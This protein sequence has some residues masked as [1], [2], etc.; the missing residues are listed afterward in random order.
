M[1]A[2]PQ[3]SVMANT[4]ITAA[5]DSLL[6]HQISE[7]QEKSDKEELIYGENAEVRREEKIFNE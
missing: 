4:E 2:S 7:S 1:N 6:D 3:V 5:S